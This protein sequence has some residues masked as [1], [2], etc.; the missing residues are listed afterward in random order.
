MCEGM[1]LDDSRRC[2]RKDDSVSEFKVIKGGHRLTGMAEE[3]RIK[4][5][6]GHVF[7]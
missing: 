6:L 3:Y 5:A 2:G 4:A 1:I 7:E